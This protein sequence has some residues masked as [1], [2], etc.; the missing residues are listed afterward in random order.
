M[1]EVVEPKEKLGN[2]NTCSQ[3]SCITA[4]VPFFKNILNVWHAHKKERAH[5]PAREAQTSDFKKYAY[6]FKFGKSS[7]F[8]IKQGENI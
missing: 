1:I 8:V 6:D 4:L 2:A 5:T 3:D 7:N